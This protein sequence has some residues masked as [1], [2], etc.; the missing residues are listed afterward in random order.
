MDNEKNIV[1]PKT[2]LIRMLEE[3]QNDALNADG[4]YYDCEYLDVEDILKEYGFE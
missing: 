4:C 1:I 2:I 3:I